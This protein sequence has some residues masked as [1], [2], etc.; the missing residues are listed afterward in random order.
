ML[1][2]A[3]T[4]LAL[5]G[6]Q[7]ERAY[8]LARI[9][10]VHV[11]LSLDRTDE[12]GA[13][14]WSNF[15]QLAGWAGGTVDR[16]EQATELIVAGLAGPSVRKSVAAAR[17]AAQSV[18]PS[19]PSELYESLN[20]LHWRVQAG[21]WDSHLHPFLKDVQMSVHLVDALLED[22][23]IHDQ[24][25][26]FVRLG[27]FVERADNVV[28]LVVRKSVEL[29]ETPDDALEWTAVLKCCFSFEAYRG[30]Y[31]APVSPEWVVGFL[32][33]DR[34]LPRSAHFAVGQALEAVRRIDDGARSRP[35]RLLA[36]LQR[37]F[38]EADPPQ[39]ARRPLDFEAGFRELR[40]DLEA[41][42]GAA[43]F[44]PNRVA[45]AV[46][47]ESSGGRMPQQQQ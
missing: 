20:A 46:Y 18:R 1:S 4:S 24:A 19:L 38:E 13:G 30:R 25:R 35:R 26:D 2:S 39:V 8:H 7:L 22:T 16:R 42:L 14:F 31:S 43:Y 21:S 11:A 37:L 41:A 27:K 33:L 9:L 47:G 40:H 10:D 32:L 29:A 34:D 45:S 3:A 5:L 12:P 36:A 28:A 6:R 23:M 44:R 17:T 15:M